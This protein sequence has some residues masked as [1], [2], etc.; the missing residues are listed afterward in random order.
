MTVSSFQ[1]EDRQRFKGYLKI[2]TEFVPEFAKKKS[3]GRSSMSVVIQDTPKEKEDV[4]IMQ[5]LKESKKSSKRQ[6]G[7]EGSNEGTGSKPGVPNESTVISATSSKGTGVK[8]GFQENKGITEEKKDDKDGDVDDE[9]DD[10]ISDTQDADDE[11]IISFHRRPI[12]KGV[13][14]RVADSHTGN[15]PEEM[16]FRSFML[17]EVDGELN[18]LPAEGVGGGQNSPS[19]KSMNNDAPVIGATPLSSVYPSNIVENVA[20]SDD[21]SYGEDEQTLVGPSLPL[22]LG[23]SKKLKILGKRKVASGVSGK[24]LPLKV[25]KVPA[26]ASKVAGEASTPLDVDSDPD[27]HEF[28]SAKELRD[29][30]DCHWVV[31]HVTP[32]SWKQRLRE[33]SIE[34]LCDIHDRAYMRQAILD[35]VLNS[36]T[37]ELIS[38]LHKAK[39]SYDAIQAQE[40]DKDRAYAGLERKCNEALQDLDKDPLVSDMRAEIKV[41]QG[42]VDGLHSEYNRLIFEERKWVNY[43]QTLS[44]LWAKIKGIESEREKLKSSEI[45]LLQEVDSLKHDRAAVVSKVIPDAAMKLVR[46]DDL[47]VLIAELVKSSIIYGR[48]QAF[49]EVAVMEEPFVLEKMSGYRPSSKEEYDRAG[50]ALANVSYPFL[51]EYVVNPYASLE[52]LLSKKPPSLRPILFESRSKPSSSKVK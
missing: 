38:A 19:K 41:L 33:I 5:D 28:P 50:D 44:S 52:Q 25:Q 24:A 31:A 14:L 9:G 6:P 3:G 7:P 42:Q 21:P 30:T 10:H 27:I 4:D 49:E 40:L 20:D 51:V 35:N 16:D 8:P 45:Q 23:A 2:V 48:C 13:G 34:Q 32:P 22:H 39:T 15:H 37:R 12:A 47:G 11:M 29:A 46:S 36:R 26:Q 17:E 43:E 1:K 18:F